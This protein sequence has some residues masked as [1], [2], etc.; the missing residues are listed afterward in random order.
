MSSSSGELLSQSTSGQ[1]EEDAREEELIQEEKK[2]K[3]E[4]YRLGARPPLITILSLLAGP[5]ISQLTNA[6][7]G[8]IDSMYISKF[9][10]P[11]GLTVVSSCYVIDY[12]AIAFGNFLNIATSSKISYLYGSGRQN[13][14]PQV[15]ADLIRVALI[16]G[17]LIPAILLPSTKPL[18]LWLSNDQ[19]IANEGFYYVLPHMCCSF[20]A[21]MYLCVLGVLEAEGRT[22]TFGFC[23]L[24]SLIANMAL[25]D[26]L[27]LIG[28]K[29]GVWGA[30][31]ATVLSEFVPMSAIVICLFKGRF[32]TRLHW[33]L[34]VQK[35]NKETYNA[36]LVAIS[37]LLMNLSTT[38]PEV[39]LQKFVSNAA[40]AIGEF[41]DIMALWNILLRLYQLA[42]CIIL[43]FNTAY[44]P[45]TSYAFGAG[46]YKR[47]LFLSLH[48]F[49]IMC[50][51]TMIVT[52]VMCIW[53]DKIA[54]IWNS[55]ERIL[56]WAK[57]IIPNNFYTMMLCPMRMLTASFLQAIKKPLLAGLVSVFTSL[58]P[59]PI[60]ST[61]TY[62]NNKTD[63]GEIFKAYIYNDTFSFVVS[64]CFAGV[65]MYKL[66]RSK[67]ND[68]ENGNSS[69]NNSYE[70]EVN[71]EMPAEA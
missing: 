6:F 12:V 20:S 65:S 31:L 1:E 25:W 45:P 32:T 68:N 69:S 21:T 3:D 17:V 39:V 42:I 63:P 54:G 33:R 24:S 61:I 46:R 35:F 44:L 70:E 29:T 2:K 9:V 13:E 71:E 38:I 18:L 28:V 30:S 58:L 23:Q 34:F 48:A 55:T 37:A 19:S 14:A 47:I 15:L 16:I 51:W 59:L 27:L 52:I 57:I 67:K 7:Y 8:I 5:L 26:P 60:F 53:P 36:L 66:L 41:N 43:A 40:R 4:H 49:W 62:L 56:Y 11:Y 64:F 10:G 22:W 50:L